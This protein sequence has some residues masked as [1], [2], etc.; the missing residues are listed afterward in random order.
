MIN[1][2]TNYNKPYISEGYFVYQINL[3]DGIKLKGTIT[4][5]KTTTNYYRTS[6]RL[7][8]GLY[9]ENNLYTIS[10][11]YIKIN[12]LEDLKEIKQLKIKEGDENKNEGRK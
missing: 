1:Q 5:E 9:I 7:L 4:H 6:S 10:E 3:T 12:Q 8:R 2:Y 11:D